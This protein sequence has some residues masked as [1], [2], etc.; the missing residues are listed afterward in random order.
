MQ[1]FIQAIS[2]STSSHL[3]VQ[4][5]GASFDDGEVEIVTVGICI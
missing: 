3:R 4:P 2:V 5:S 1:C